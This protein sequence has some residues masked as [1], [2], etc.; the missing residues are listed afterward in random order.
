MRF[1][2]E[3]SRWP[4][5]IAD[6]AEDVTQ[7]RMCVAEAAREMGLPPLASGATSPVSEELVAEFCRWGG[8][9][10]HAVAAVMGG[11]AS[12]EV[13]KAATHQYLPLNTT[14]IF[15]G[16]NGTTATLEL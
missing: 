2:A 7:L 12:Q 13:I 3:R 9:E 6:A 5:A 10:I 16:R 14:F 4:G 1:R 11:V 15:N 8:A